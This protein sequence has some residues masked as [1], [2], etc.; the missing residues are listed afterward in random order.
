MP[1]PAQLQ[2]LGDITVGSGEGMIAQWEAV[3]V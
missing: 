3:R 1:Y 2:R